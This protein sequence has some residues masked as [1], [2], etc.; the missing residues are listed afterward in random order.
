M[1]A[2]AH[3][4]V[5]KFPTRRGVSIQQLQ[6][7]YKAPD[8]LDALQ[9]FLTSRV[10]RDRLVL[11]VESDTFDV[12]N[13]LYIESRPSVVTGHSSG[14]R[15]I[16]AKPKVAARGRKAES[17]AR[18]DTAFVWD[19]GRRPSFFSMAD[20]MY[21]ASLSWQVCFDECFTQGCVSHKYAS[22]S[23][24]L[25][26]LDSTHIRWRTLSGLPHSVGV[27]PFP[28]SSSSPIRHAIIGETCQ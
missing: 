10:P 8:F 22:Y 28:A 3:Y 21:L 14:W 17:P 7:D 16:R 23:S 5:A 6:S 19:E 26:I 2:K 4:K 9:R 12:F 1:L 25:D 11:P 24:S 20:G 27:I 18:F 13:H 15:K